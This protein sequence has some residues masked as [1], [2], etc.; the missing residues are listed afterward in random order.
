[1]CFRFGLMHGLR[2][3]ISLSTSSSPFPYCEPGR[4][5]SAYLPSIG[6]KLSTDRI[7]FSTGVSRHEAR[8]SEIPVSIALL[9]VSNSPDENVEAR[10]T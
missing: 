1:M 6:W 9:E 2:R 10:C 5:Y 7:P 3:R 8:E 4:S